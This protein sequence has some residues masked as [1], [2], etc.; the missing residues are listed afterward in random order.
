MKH[1]K[2]FSA[3]ELDKKC[4]PKTIHWLW[5]LI[6]HKSLLILKY[7]NYSNISF[8]LEICICLEWK[9]K[10][11]MS[12][13]WSSWLCSVLSLVV[14]ISVRWNESLFN[15]IP[16]IPISFLLSISQLCGLWLVF[17]IIGHF[18]QVISL[19][20]VWIID[21]LIVPQDFPLTLSC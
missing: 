1:S 20:S 4:K 12:E 3:F 7:L 17:K 13:F 5:K 21:D 14:G 9:L 16:K 6:I 11:L 8:F 15:W 18:T 10:W 2:L 19:L